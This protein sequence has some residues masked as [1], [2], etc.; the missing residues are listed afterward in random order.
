MMKKR[1]E[2]WSTPET[3][4]KIWRLSLLSSTVRFDS[5]IRSGPE[6]EVV[7]ITPDIHE[8]SGCFPTHGVSQLAF[9]I[10]GAF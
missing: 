7:A 3:V 6:H 4:L 8:N 10:R 9:T 1:T 5:E 2:F